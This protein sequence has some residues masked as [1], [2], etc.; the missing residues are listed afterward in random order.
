[1]EYF[2]F[3]TMPVEFARLFQVNME[4][5]GISF[6]SL[7]TKAVSNKAFY[8]LAKMS[9][10][11]ESGE[12]FD[13]SVILKKLGWHGVRDKLANQYLHFAK[14]N[15]YSKKLETTLIHDLVDLEEDYSL[16][17]VQGFSRAYLLGFYFKLWELQGENPAYAKEIVSIIRDKN[18]KSLIEISSNR[19]AQTDVMILLMLHFKDFLGMEKLKSLISS[20]KGF[21]TIYNSLSSE[22]RNLLMRNISRYLL[23]VGD[24]KM[25][26]T[27]LPQR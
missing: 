17:S 6:K 26:T 14:Y 23:S 25:L 11:S 21:L 8:S 27:L 13:F 3:V 15:Q 20:A 1:M 10:P 19:I 22:N 2:E 24:E 9:F 7:P 5:V 4:S 12:E 18:F 16:Y